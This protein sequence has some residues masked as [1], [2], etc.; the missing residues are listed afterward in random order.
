MSRVYYMQLRKILSGVGC[1]KEGGADCK[2]Y[3]AKTNK[4]IA[5]LMGLACFESELRMAKLGFLQ[6]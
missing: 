6:N 1:D 5:K 4:E 2:I 3:K